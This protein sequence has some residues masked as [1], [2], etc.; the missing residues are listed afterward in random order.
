MS[1]NLSKAQ[2]IQVLPP[3]PGYH[4]A[5][6]IVT[7][8][9]G[10]QRRH[11]IASDGQGSVL[12]DQAR[13][14]GIEVTGYGPFINWCDWCGERPAAPG[15]PCDV[16]RKLGAGPAFRYEQTGKGQP[17]P[18]STPEPETVAFIS[19]V[20]MLGLTP[21]QAKHLEG[22]DRLNFWRNGSLNVQAQ[23]GCRGIKLAC[24]AAKITDVDLV[25]FFLAWGWEQLGQKLYFKPNAASLVRI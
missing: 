17:A 8:K 1:I 5:T 21:E 2:S 12:L 3:A 22:V 20:E 13:E 16:C 6:A 19:L 25:L 15:E 14:A 24:P 11:S 18:E 10:Q 23:H 4:S 7:Y 9:S